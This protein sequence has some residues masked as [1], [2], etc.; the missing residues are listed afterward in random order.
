MMAD[1]YSLTKEEVLNKLKS[2]ADNG[3]ADDQVISRIKEYGK[4]ELEN[5]GAKSPWKI[6]WEQFKETMIVILIIAAIL[7]GVLGEET[8]AIAI[9]AIVVLFAILGFIQEYRAEKAMAELKKLSV[10]DVIAVRNGSLKELSALEL[11]PGDIIKLEAGNIVPADAR[12]IQ[13]ADLKV[14]EAPLTGES[15]SIE[16]QTDPL[17]SETD[18]AERKNMV[19]MG[20]TIT[21]GRGVA[22]VVETGM[23]TELGNIADMLQEVQADKTPLQNKLNQLGKTLAIGGGIAAVLVGAIG[24]AGG[25]SFQEMFLVAISLAVAVV[26]EGLPAV[27]TITLALG[28]RK[29]LRKNALI[30][31]LPAVET[32]GSVT[33]ICS[34]KTGTLT[35]N[36]MTVSHIGTIGGLR[37]FSKNF[38]KD[39]EKQACLV[40]LNGL[41]CNDS[42]VEK[43]GSDLN[44]I[45]E[46]TES[47]LLKAALEAG[48]KVKKLRK[49]VVRLEEVAF[50]SERMMMS[51][52][53]K[54]EDID[55]SGEFSG[56]DFLNKPLVVFTKGAADTIL[57]ISNRVLKEDGVQTFSEEDKEAIRQMNE[58]IAG[59]GGRVLCF[60]MK[61]ID[62]IP[63]DKQKLEEEMIFVGMTGLWDPPRE[64]VKQ[65]VLTCKQAGIRPVMITGDHHLTAVSIAEKVNF[66]EKPEFLNG[67]ELNGTDGDEL[68][69]QIREVSVFARVAPENKL[70]IVKAIQGSGE[71]VAMTGDGVNDAPA[72][73]KAD[74]GIA[75]GITGTDVSKEAADMVLLDDNFTSIIAAVEEGRVI[76]DNLLRFVEFSLSGNLAKV[77][78]MLFAPVIGIV[79]ALTPLQLLWLNLLTDGLLG[80]GL[81]VEPAEKDVMARP[82]RR[83]D[84]PILDKKALIHVGWI[85]LFIGVV[86]MTISWYFYQQ[87]NDSWQ[88]I[89][90][91]TIGFAQAGQA[92][93][94]RATSIS[95]VSISSNWLF[96]GMVFLVLILQI[97]LVFLPWGTSIFALKP[98]S[99]SEF[100]ICTLAG[101]LVFAV[102][103][104]EKVLNM[105]K[106]N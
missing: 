54:T 96:S 22:V 106:R 83:P 17:K 14:Q 84:A 29:M 8:E 30:R 66:A 70:K 36:E 27:V 20:T 16:K 11:V 101:I 44:V 52:V 86:S 68:K 19:F 91:L 75:M 60:A 59:K 63:Q 100:L 56:L 9:L 81:G 92:L 7:S 1:W 69:K 42:E 10:P 13:V 76:F 95:P 80:L 3:L 34:D 57:S 6:L 90:F 78:V 79:V 53:H 47:A 38:P 33:T 41:L 88:T 4:N 98:L 48:L 62:E 46:P 99:W 105:N 18:L 58:E 50:D 74:I 77:L 55:K 93:G 12:L 31:R 87:G 26:P 65:A 89:L 40:L 32:L 82:P 28:S 24:L 64:E 103:R 15:L 67:S 94:L 102:V 73:K 85:G 25:R 49:K 104:I 37:E 21:H 97:G 5:K 2:S 39:Q 45:G 72:L 61:E 23:N 71:I 43:V 35:R 51:T